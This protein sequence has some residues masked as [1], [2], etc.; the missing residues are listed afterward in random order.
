MNKCKNEKE[1][2]I[3]LVALIVTIIILLILA[4]I[5]IATLTNTGLLNKSK[6]AEQK[7]K[8]A[9]ELENGTLSEYEEAIL[10]AS[11]DTNVTND[12]DIEITSIIDASVNEK[13]DVK[14]NFENAVYVY[15][16]NNKIS[17]YTDKNSYTA[18]NLNANEKYDLVVIVV[19]GNG[20]I[21]K[22]TK[23]FT[24]RKE[25]IDVYGEIQNSG[26]S[27]EE[28]GITYT[29][30]G[31]DQYDYNK[32]YQLGMGSWS[33][34]NSNTYTLKINYNTLISQLENKNFNGIYG[35]FYHYSESDYSSYTS[36]VYSKIT[37]I[38]DD[39]TTSETTTDT[40]YASGIIN[41]SEP[42][43]TVV[44]EKGK[45]VTEIQMIISEYDSNYGA[46]CG[47]IKNIGLIQ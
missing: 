10:S 4:G 12:L 19:E 8:D 44:F 41:T 2:A 3:T 31:L 47:Y 46:A 17:A 21:H 22:G 29:K 36:W 40:L 45:K 42:F 1:K 38:Y 32:V 7:S 23:S 25:N 33:G 6:Q 43:A 16:L 9:Q 27:L 35:Q 24:T 20:N 15:I 28:Y 13:I 18:E 34:T 26:K 39:N 11:R 37:V 14:Q 5:T 30:Q